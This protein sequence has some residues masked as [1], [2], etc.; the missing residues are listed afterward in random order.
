MGENYQAIVDR[1]TSE[2]EAPV[3]GTLIRDWLVSEGVIERLTRDCV[4]STDSGYPPGP[5]HANV[6]EEVNPYL[7]NLRTNGL[8]II[9][10]RRPYY[11]LTGDELHLIC[12]TCER[13]F[14]SPDEHGDAIEEWF[15]RKGIGLLPCPSCGTAKPISEWRHEPPWAF[16]NLGFEFWNWYPL[17]SSFI[18]EVSQRLGHKVLLVG[19]K[20]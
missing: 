12:D 15:S 7:M 4:L 18:A 2:D 13:R 20:F 19:G 8:A 14:V 9:T 3:L 16:G 11:S 17:K 1:E 6:T 10:E 5:N